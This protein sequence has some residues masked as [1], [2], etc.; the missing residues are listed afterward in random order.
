[1]NK[2]V[3]N[4]IM[5]I[6]GLAEDFYVPIKKIWDEFGSQSGLLTYEDLITFF[7]K[8][9]KFEIMEP[10]VTK[11]DDNPDM[12]EDGFYS[13]PRVKLRSRKITKEDMQ[14][15]TLRHAQ[16]VVDNLVKAYEVKPEDLPPD[17]EDE[18]IELMK[19]A[20]QLKETISEAFKKKGK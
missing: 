11:E 2:E 15:I 19:R 3:L 8:N 7:K 13:G 16:N 5:S 12:E 14:R 6:L 1:M 4:E 9:R 20:K 18:L 10:E 17:K